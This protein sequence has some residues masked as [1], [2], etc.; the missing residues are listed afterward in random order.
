MGF[1]TAMSTLLL[2]TPLFIFAKASLTDVCT[3]PY[4]RAAL[5][6]DNFIN[7]VVLSSSSITVNIVTNYSVA[8]N[9][10]FPGKDGLDF[11]NVTFSYTH[12]G[13]NDTVCTPSLILILSV[14]Y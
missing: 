2:L 10:L 11:C 7:G 3:T 4:V 6:A 8:A 9:D 12:T 14:R 5:P 1:V 13:L